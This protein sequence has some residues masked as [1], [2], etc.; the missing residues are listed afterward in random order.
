MKN[1]LEGWKSLCDAEISKTK[2]LEAICVYE[3]ARRQFRLRESILSPWLC[4]QDLTMVFAGR[5]IGKT[6]FALG[7]A[8][9]V[10]TGGSFL[11]WKA[12][13][14]R[15]VLYLDGEMSGTSMQGR[16]ALH[17]G[18][19]APAED[20]L[21]VFTPDLMEDNSHLMPDLATSDG[22]LEIGGLIHQ[23]TELII[24]DNLSCWCRT[25][26]END[27]ESWHPIAEWILSLRRMGKAVLLVHHAGKGGL[28][29]G[30]S[31]KE[32]LLD[33]VIGLSR[34]EDY[35]ARQGARFVVE[36]TKGRHLLQGEGESLVVSLEGSDKAARWC[37]STLEASTYDRV[38]CLAKEDMSQGEIASELGINK[39]QVS[40]HLK[41]ARDVGDYIKKGKP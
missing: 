12:D 20:Y 36:F 29:R 24:V 39:S 3:L 22:Q 15:K 35:E 21:R 11:D 23:D 17:L 19:T 30:T 28:Q 14:P 18:D 25:G 2:A 26:R 6:H 16:I 41:K 27:S 1:D 10:A 32:D 4:V 40:R 34:P 7:V 5:G 9:A 31:K 13:K 37:W 8:I 33:A 38:L